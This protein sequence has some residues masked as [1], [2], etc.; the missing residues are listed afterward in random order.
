MLDS[1]YLAR[2]G[3]RNRIGSYL[4]M[5]LLVAFTLTGY[6]VVGSYW[7]DASK[8]SVATT[9]PLNFPYLKTTVI[10]AYYS[11]PPLSP[12][13]EFPPPRKYVPLFNEE[14]LSRIR[15]LDGVKSLSV[16]LCQEIF[17]RYGNREL[18]SIEPGAP[19]W[20]EVDLLEGRLPGA[21]HEI[22]V[23]QDLARAGAAV[24]SELLLIK[25]SS[26]IPKQYVQDRII[27]DIRDPL[28]VCNTLVVGVYAPKTPMISGYVSYLA[29]NRVESYPTLNPKCVVMPWPVPNTIFLGLTEP[30]KAESVL[31][32]WRSL[33]PD[34]PG[35]EVPVIPP[36]KTSWTPDLPVKLMESAT[37][38]IA[39]P[40]FS[41]TLNAFA[42]GAIGIFASMFTAFLDRRHE[43]GI[44][45]TLGIDNRHTSV[46][47]SLE[48]V[49]AGIFGT[50]LGIL[51]AFAITSSYLKGITGNF[52]E[53]PWDV[54]FKGIT[55]SAGLL[56][57][58]TFVP[59]AMA[60]RGTVM[61]L[62]QGRIIP[63]FRKMRT[64]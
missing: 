61:E 21:S 35:T 51:G 45:K 39:S 34:L 9:E 14:E 49:F 47:V 53:L 58:A 56:A 23:P 64:E 41:N 55:L 62:L 17:S 59:R 36:P 1:L 48:V 30:A 27:K 40:V 37:S 50:A 44:M 54:V 3:F 24:G 42:L 16:A 26:I 19:L 13:E 18:L 57:G 10:Y 6:L 12:D 46:T 8:V 63:I 43:L 11:N 60:E 20:D 4:V 15:H 33:Y 2:R 32:F 5:T 38:H 29:V 52:I 25:P 22:L 7:R 28:P 31:Y